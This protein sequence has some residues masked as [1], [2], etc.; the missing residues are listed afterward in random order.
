MNFTNASKSTLCGK[1]NFGSYFVFQNLLYSWL[2]FFVLQGII[3]LQVYCFQLLFLLNYV[4]C[5]LWYTQKEPQFQMSKRAPCRPIRAALFFL[6]S[7]SV[8]FKHGM[9]FMRFTRVF[10]LMVWRE[11]LMKYNQKDLPSAYPWTSEL[12]AFLFV[13]F[14][15]KRS[16]FVPHRYILHDWGEY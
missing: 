8:S 5:A 11:I 2:G 1:N 16:R 6:Q 14:A 10:Q 3:W 15:L 13:L 9:R 4:Y 12:K 7:S